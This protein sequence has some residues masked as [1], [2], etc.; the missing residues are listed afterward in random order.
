MRSSISQVPPS[1]LLVMFR[2]E[3][4]LG[5]EGDG[6]DMDDLDGFDSFNSPQLQDV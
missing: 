1:R 4:S 5:G 2:S 6:G 3:D